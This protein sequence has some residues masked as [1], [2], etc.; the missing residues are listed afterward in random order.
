VRATEIDPRG[1]GQRTPQPRREA[2]GVDRELRGGEPGLKSGR[3]EKSRELVA[4]ERPEQGFGS[5]SQI[6]QRRIGG[7]SLCVPCLDGS[8][9]GDERVRAEHRIASHE[10]ME[11]GRGHEPFRVGA[12]PA[13]DDGAKAER[14]L[15]LEEGRLARGV[16]RV[17]EAEVDL[18]LVAQA[19]PVERD[20]VLLHERDRYA[21][22]RELEG[23]ARALQAGSQHEN[24]CL[25]FGHEG[26]SAGFY[27]PAAVARDRRRASDRGE[28]GG[29]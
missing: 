26:V 23:H 8:I 5:R 19:R 18:A 22:A 11:R 27:T 14:A 17:D 9:V 4:M 3:I 6:V 2:H 25:E 16:V 1:C 24:P 7:D 13:A 15:E 20:L 10:V 28:E 21:A 29:P 12:E